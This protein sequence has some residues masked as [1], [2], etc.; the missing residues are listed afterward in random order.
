M[1]A[2]LTSRTT[3]W[4]NNNHPMEQGVHHPVR[5]LAPNRSN[6][7]PR[8]KRLQCHVFSRKATTLTEAINIAAEMEAFLE[9]QVRH[10]KGKPG[11]RD[12]RV[13][14]QT[15]HPK[16]EA[17]EERAN[18]MRPPRHRSQVKCYGCH[19]LGHFRRDCP[20]RKRAF[21]NKGRVGQAEAK[22]KRQTP[23]GG[24]QG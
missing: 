21:D 10:G 8:Q 9:S 6:P 3:N 7:Y 23:G 14:F 22:R 4:P 17:H 19:G 15:P 2:V 5:G 1:V 12:V 16:P 13:V 20:H 18:T 24:P 11:A